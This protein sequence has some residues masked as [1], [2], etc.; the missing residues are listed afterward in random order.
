MLSFSQEEAITASVLWFV[1]GI[2]CCI[3][4]TFQDFCSWLQIM[5]T[6]LNVFTSLCLEA[7]NLI[8]RKCSCFS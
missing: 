2:Q 8:C 7:T 1:H 4:Q 3:G 5:N 6:S